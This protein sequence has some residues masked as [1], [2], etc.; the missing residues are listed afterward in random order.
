[1]TFLRRPWAS[2]LAALGAYGVLATT[3]VT[4]VGVVGE[5]DATWGASKAPTVVVGWDQGEPVLSEGPGGLLVSSQTRPVERLSLG[6]VQVPL[7]VNA[8]TGGLAD[9]PARALHR[10]TGS[11]DAVVALHVILGGILVVLCHRFLWFHGTKVAAGVASLALAADWSFV[12]YRKVLGGTEVLLQAGA[13]LA[14]WALWSRRWRGGRHGSDAIAMG[15]GIGLLAKATFVPTGLALLAAASLTRRDRPDMKPPAPLQLGRAAAIVG[16]CMAPL[17]I[18]WLHQ[19]FFPLDT[20]VRSHDTLGLQLERLVSSLGSLAGGTVPA[21]ETGSTLGWFFFW[22]LRWFEA[23]HGAD[24]PPGMGPWRLVGLGVLAGG[25][26]RAWRGQERTPSSALLRFLSLFVPM[27]VVALWLSN[28]DLHHLAQA[29]MGLC[30]WLGLA[31]DRLAAMVCPPRSF[32]RAGLGLALGLPWILSGARMLVE[33]DPMLATVEDPLVTD[34][35]QEGLEQ[36]LREHGVHR[37]WTTDYTLYGMLEVRMPGLEATHAWAAV[38]NRLGERQAFLADLLPKARGGHYLVVRPTDPLI[39]NLTPTE[40]E[41]GAAAQAL[42]IP[43][44]RVALLEDSLGP[45]ARLYEVP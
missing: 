23:A 13:L 26:I 40:D 16:V 11:R 21:R 17:W 29:S 43:L 45:W 18:T 30:L 1:M 38:A 31:A 6:N 19:G 9:W 35:G 3:T 34:E 12:Y 24:V 4:G 33:T 28:H 10:V 15:L 32:R 25:T 42:G 2:L 41:M 44:R 5:V 22:P 37:V 7:A 39:Y 8:Y 36:M 27:Q 20:P 14:L